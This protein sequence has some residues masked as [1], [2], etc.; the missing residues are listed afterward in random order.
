MSRFAN[1]P[2]GGALG[3]LWW[4]CD[5]WE[6]RGR[7]CLDLSVYCFALG[8]F[9]QWDLRHSYLKSGAFQYLPITV[10]RASFH[11]F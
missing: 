9:L 3:P 1:S 4:H 10:S 5:T 8:D 2:N 11:C 7:S 6:N